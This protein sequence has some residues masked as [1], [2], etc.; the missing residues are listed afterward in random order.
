MLLADQH[1]E[2]ILNIYREYVDNY[3]QSARN[4]H[5]YGVLSSYLRRMR[6]YPSGDKLVRSLCRNWINRYP[7]RKVMVEELRKELCKGT[8]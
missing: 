5:N 7:T 6:Q 2:Q 4:R 3:A 8:L 1:A